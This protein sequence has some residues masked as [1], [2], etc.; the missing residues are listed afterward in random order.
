MKNKLITLLIILA[1]LAVYPVWRYTSN[2]KIFTNAI[3]SHVSN[4]GEW[5]YSS[6]HSGF[7]GKITIRNLIFTPNGY[8]QGFNIGSAIISTNPMFILKTSA[9]KLEYM[10]PETLSISLNT[11]TLDSKG[12]DMET[13]FKER[14]LWMLIAGYAGSFG[15]SRDSYTSFD[16]ASWKDIFYREQI[17]NVDLYYSRQENGTLDVDL[18]LDAE[19]QFTSTWSSN[20]KTS[21]VDK[22]IVVDELIVDKL[23]Y[24]Y[25]DNGFNSTRN[26]ACKKNHKSSLAAYRLSSSENVQKYF[27]SNYAK[28]LSQ[29]LISLY[30]RLLVPDI[31]YN[32]IIT[33]D[34]RKYLT[35]IYSIGQKELLVNSMVEISTTQNEYL[36]VTLTEIDYK[37]IDMDVIKKENLAREI[38]N[39]KKREEALKP[40]TA[41]DYL[42]PK[43]F[44]T[45]KKNTR[46]LS[47]TKIRTVINR[48]VRLKTTRGRPITGY[49][50]SVDGDIVTIETKYKTGIAVL[51]V[52]LSKISSVELM[53]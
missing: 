19:N 42:K 46:I 8:T 9:Y 1:V 23:F 33:L 44:T 36:P 50:R 30:Q 40:K 34:E 29:V 18:L 5:E 53:K 2:A 21:Y 48:R 26:D 51:S 43:I 7:D 35:D 14:S 49:L 17:Y 41:K 20:L 25:L 11:A 6:T 32:T 37:G 47:V 39:A 28:E 16:D 45:G 15:C 4:M 27:R 3:L 13:M 31:E 52:E 24:S 12:Y 10:L 22:Q 38:N